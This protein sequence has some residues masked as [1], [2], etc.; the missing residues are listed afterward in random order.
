MQI[1]DVMTVRQNIVYPELTVVQ[2]TNGQCIA[3][4]CD[5][6]QIWMDR[7][8]KKECFKVTL[9]KIDPDK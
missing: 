5:E 2:L 6:F 3:V 4:P 1:Q 9:V 8:S 7:D